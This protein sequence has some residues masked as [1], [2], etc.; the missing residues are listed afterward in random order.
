MIN[1]MPRIYINVTTY[2]SHN[3]MLIYIL[4]VGK[5]DPFFPDILEIGLDTRI[6]Y[7]QRC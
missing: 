5:G 2:P 1:Y 3:P 6:L 4:C 7:Q